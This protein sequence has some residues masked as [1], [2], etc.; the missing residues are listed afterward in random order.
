MTKLE[1][2]IYNWK[3]VVFIREKSKYT[4]LPGF[5]G[6]PLY[7][8]FVYFMKQSKKISLNERAAAISFNFIMAIPAACIFL[9]TLLPY[10]P[11]SK[12]IYHELFRFVRDITPDRETRK[13]IISF[14]DDFFNKPKTGLL[15]V[16]FLLAVFYSSNAMMGVIRTFDRSLQNTY[17]GGFFSKRLRAIRLTTIVIVLILATSLISLG[18]GTLFRWLMDLLG[19]E[20]RNLRFWIQSLRWLV[21]LALFVYSIGLIY[22]YAPSVK[23]RWKL[24]S[25][26]AFLATF[27]TISV[28]SVFSIWVQHFSNYNKVYGSIGTLLI[29]MLLISLNSLILLIGF[30]LNVSITHLKE[31]RTAEKQ[32]QETPSLALR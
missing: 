15:S 12:Q 11:V 10:L 17:K 25:P 28:T 8:V 20:N 26:G 19:I 4:I 21:I 30:E 13:V 29:I 7:D 5:E 2:I 3:P 24:L 1:R 18:Q 32:K 31:Q 22:K 9:F 23:K 27:L 6:L 16:G 14:L